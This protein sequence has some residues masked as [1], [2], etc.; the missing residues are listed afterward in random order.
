MDTTKK[1]ARTLLKNLK[2]NQANSFTAGGPPVTRL[3]ITEFDGFVFFP[4]SAQ[5]QAFKNR[6]PY[7]FPL[8]YQ[9][10]TPTFS[11]ESQSFQQAYTTLNDCQVT[12]KAFRHELETRFADSTT[13]FETQFLEPYLQKIE[14]EKISPI[15]CRLAHQRGCRDLQNTLLLGPPVSKGRFFPLQ[16]STQAKTFADE[17]GLM[18]YLALLFYGHTKFPPAKLA[19]VVRQHLQPFLKQGNW[20]TDQVK[21]I[22]DFLTKHGY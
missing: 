10:K 4:T 21:E 9:A 6:L 3:V 13:A 20:S 1:F 16:S 17:H 8:P 18:V 11:V 2:L 7:I 19:P 15:W 12:K 5:S 22:K 14:S